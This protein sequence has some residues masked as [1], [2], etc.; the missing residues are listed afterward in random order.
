LHSITVSACSS[1]PL[2][3]AMSNGNQGVALTVLAE[4]R[5]DLA[6]ADRGQAQISAAFETCRDAD[7]SNAAYDHAK[8]HTA[9]A[10]VEQLRRG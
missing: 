9:Q 10:L 4:R 1:P 3:W 7:H 8:L 6:M 2:D 5:R